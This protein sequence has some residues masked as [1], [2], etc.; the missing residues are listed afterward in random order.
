[1]PYIEPTDVDDL[2]EAIR[3]LHKEGI[4]AT[5][6]NISEQLGLDSNAKDDAM[7]HRLLA[8]GIEQGLVKYDTQAEYKLA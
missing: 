5:F 7:L 6:G 8:D 4:W 2:V 1:M 3:Q